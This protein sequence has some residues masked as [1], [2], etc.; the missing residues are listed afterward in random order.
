MISPGDPG[1]VAGVGASRA[2]ELA[3]RR[4]S[5]GRSP[6]GARRCGWRSRRAHWTGPAG[7]PRDRRRRLV[8]VPVADLLLGDLAPAEP[9]VRAA[10]LGG[11]LPGRP[12][13]RLVVEAVPG[14]ADREPGG[15]RPPR[16]GMPGQGR[17]DLHRGVGSPASSRRCPSARRR[18]VHRPSVAHYRRKRSTAERLAPRRSVARPLGGGRGRP[19]QAGAASIGAGYLSRRRNSSTSS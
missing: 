17:E 11:L 3:P 13:A 8:Q 15:C 19:A 2:V 16:L 5:R 10:A 9:R 18:A 4:R 1:L 14:V 7:R 6:S 12:R